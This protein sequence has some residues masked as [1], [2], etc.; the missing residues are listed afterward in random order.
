MTR[1][2]ELTAMVPPD[3]LTQLRELAKRTQWSMSQ[4]VRA[5]LAAY[6]AAQQQQPKEAGAA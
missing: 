6:L 3:M 4:H 2:T 5:A 1:L